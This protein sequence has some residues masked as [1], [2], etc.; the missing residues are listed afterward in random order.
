MIYTVNLTNDLNSLKELN[1]KELS[2][3]RESVNYIEH[4]Q[5][6]I[7]KESEDQKEKIKELINNNNNKKTNIYIMKSQ[8]YTKVRKKTRWKLTS[9]PNITYHLLC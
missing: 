8:P 5:K 4:G 1:K 6:F 7:E 9:S 2:K 3:V